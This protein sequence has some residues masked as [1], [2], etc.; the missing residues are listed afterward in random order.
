MTRRNSRICA[1]LALACVAFISSGL[2]ASGV[3]I[4]TT[5]RE[6]VRFESNGQPIELQGFGLVIGLA[7]TGDS[8]KE[9]A[10][11]R[12]LAAALT[13]RGFPI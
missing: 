3:F 2:S 1:L 10:I 9:L 11:A 6:L 13:Q 12:P 5:I 8:S 7:G 4:G